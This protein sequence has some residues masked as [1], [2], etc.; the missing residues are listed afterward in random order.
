MPGMSRDARNL[1]MSGAGGFALLCK[2]LEFEDFTYTLHPSGAPTRI[3]IQPL[4][5]VTMR[6][7][8]AFTTGRT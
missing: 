4:H 7:P 5:A 1:T 6:N 3:V 8:V 2:V